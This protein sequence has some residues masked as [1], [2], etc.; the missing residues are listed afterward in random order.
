MKCALIQTCLTCSTV[1]INHGQIFPSALWAAIIPKIVRMRAKSHK[2]NALGHIWWNEKNAAVMMRVLAVIVLLPTI[3][4][5]YILLVAPPPSD[6]PSN[7]LNNHNF[8]P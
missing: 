2:N 1:E 6:L 7:A 5:P 8:P 4:P 3:F